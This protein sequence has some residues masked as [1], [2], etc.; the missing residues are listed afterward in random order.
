M[1][2]LYWPASPVDTTW[3]GGLTAPSKDCSHLDSMASPGA[4]W[5]WSHSQL[6][7]VLG[8]SDCSERIAYAWPFVTTVACFVLFSCFI[9]VLLVACVVL[10][11]SLHAPQPVLFCAVNVWTFLSC[12]C[13]YTIP[14][15]VCTCTHVQKKL[16]YNIV[17]CPCIHIYSTT[18]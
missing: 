3:G 5:S 16:Q 17:V 2:G 8:P 13:M 14:I 1:P 18:V 10:S 12:A 4:H 6:S 9:L 7:S 15:C 11:A